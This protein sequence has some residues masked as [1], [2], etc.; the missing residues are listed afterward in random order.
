[1]RKTLF[2]FICGAAFSL[3]ATSAMAEDGYQLV[4]KDHVFTP[5]SLE[6]PAGQK[7]KLKIVN[8]DPTPE[9][10]ESYD[11]NREKVIG[12]NSE[13]IVFIGPLESGTYKFVGEFNE[14]TAKGTIV[15]K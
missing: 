14:K 8:Q 1:M 2:S 3:I 12:G 7:I 4:I 6:V 5:A 11:L 10:F 13:G 15:A 9:E